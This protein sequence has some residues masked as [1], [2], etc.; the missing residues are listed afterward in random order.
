MFKGTLFITTDINMAQQLI[1]TS[2][3]VIIG[4]SDQHTSQ[5]LNGIGGSILLPPY[6]AMMAQMDGNA[7][8]FY[9]QYYLHLYTKEPQEFI[10]TILRALMIGTNIVLYCSEDEFKLCGQFLLQFLQ[11]DFGIVVGTPNNPFYF[12]PSYIPA[13]CTLLYIN[14]LIKVDEL[15]MLY[16]DN[17]P[18]NDIIL[19]KLVEELH[20]VV[21]VQ[22]TQ[23]YLNYF[24][25]L[26][27]RVK[28]NKKFMKAPIRMG[29]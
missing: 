24:N 18:I 27:H 4:E 9:N 15:F 19:P 25:N 6:A 2:K 26:N 8:Q 7:D 29:V 12:D 28:Q 16:P 3:I 14:D 21:D 13:I 22:S 17:V 23:G 1:Y 20:P 5:I 10:A 11:R